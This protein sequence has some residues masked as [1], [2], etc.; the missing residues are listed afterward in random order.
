MTTPDRLAEVAAML[1]ARVRDDGP[2]DNAV[3]LTGALPDP[4]DWF[5][6]CFVLAAA[7]PDD[8]TWAELTA[9]HTGTA[10]PLEL[11]R[12]QWRDAQHKRGSMKAQ[13]LAHPQ[14][15]VMQA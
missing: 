2:E 7:V 12:Q 5:R 14:A 1:A 15:M 3:W 13:G 6:L 11:R 4:A 8:R 9:W 10:D